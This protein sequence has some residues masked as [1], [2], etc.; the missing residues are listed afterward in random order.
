MLETQHH[1]QMIVVL[2][3]HEPNCS[4]TWVIFPNNKL[5]GVLRAQL[6]IVSDRV[7]GVEIPRVLQGISYPADP[8]EL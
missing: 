5:Y 4:Q 3:L 2:T 8:L 1:K 6:Q 7:I